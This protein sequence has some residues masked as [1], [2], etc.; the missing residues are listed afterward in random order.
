MRKL[1]FVLIAIVLLSLASCSDFPIA[2]GAEVMIDNHTYRFTLSGWGGYNVL[3]KVHTDDG[4]ELYISVEMYSI[5]KK[6]D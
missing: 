6:K 5:G 4:R 1:G 3:E 2:D